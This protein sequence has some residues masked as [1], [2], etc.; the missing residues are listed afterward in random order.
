MMTRFL[1]LMLI[2]PFLAFLTIRLG[3]KKI[4]DQE[5]FSMLWAKYRTTLVVTGVVVIPLIS[6]RI[7]F[8]VSVL[9][10]S[11]LSQNEVLRL[12]CPGILVRVI[13]LMA[14]SLTLVAGFVLG[15]AGLTTGL[16][17]STVLLFCCHCFFPGQGASWSAYPQAVMSLVYP[18]L[19]WGFYI[20]CYGLP[21]GPEFLLYFYCVTEMNNSF[22][23]LVGSMAGKT[24]IFPGISPN[25]TW[26][27]VLGGAAAAFATGMVFNYVGFK[28]PIGIAAA[29][30]ILIILGATAGDLIASGIKRN[31]GVKNFGQVLP[32]HGGIMDIF[33]SIIFTAPFFYS[34]ILAACLGTAW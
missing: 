20:L 29:S 14:G 34:F 4:D 8:L 21:K 22:A 27:G 17:F 18:S 11:A 26:E 19:F 24:K 30:T 13:A 23:Q 28:F 32:N 12:F 16:V 6:G 9:V 5:L 3:S 2:M 33:D 15:M 1:I 10:L 31:F 7:P 25:K